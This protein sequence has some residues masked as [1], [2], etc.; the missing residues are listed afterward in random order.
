V[1]E[2]LFEFLFEV[3]GEALL[4]LTLQALAEAGLHIVRRPASAGAA[5]KNTWTL[6]IGY[7]LLGLLIG[8]L[9]L[10]IFPHSLVHTKLARVAVVVVSALTTGASMAA[11]GAWRRSH[12]Q[13]AIPLDR[14]AYGCLLGFSSASVRF[15]WAQ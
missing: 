8:G 9:S 6:V 12:G 14:F 13:Q 4:Q 2:L 7:A 11:I 3:F 5:E 15:L 1:L 10:L